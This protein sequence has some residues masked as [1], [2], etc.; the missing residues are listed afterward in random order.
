MTTSVEYISATAS[1]RNES[2][3]NGQTEILVCYR[4]MNWSKLAQFEPANRVC[5]YGEAWA[6]TAGLGGMHTTGTARFGQP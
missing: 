4:G 3:P 5:C 6:E 2:M 1:T